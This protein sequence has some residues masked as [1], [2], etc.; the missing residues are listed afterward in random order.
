[1]SL[2]NEE[3]CNLGQECWANSIFLTHLM[4]DVWIYNAWRWESGLMHLNCET[5]GSTWFTQLNMIQNIFFLINETFVRPLMQTFTENITSSS[6]LRNIYSSETQ[7]VRRSIFNVL[8]HFSW[9][10]DKLVFG[11]MFVNTLSMFRRTLTDHMMKT[12]WFCDPCLS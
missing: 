4:V 7:Q 9:S 10:Y 6:N 3:I 8:M 5:P 12:N 2:E 11:S 1:L